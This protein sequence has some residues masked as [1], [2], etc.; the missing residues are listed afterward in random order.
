MSKLT[1]HTALYPKDGGFVSAFYVVLDK[2]KDEDGH[3][4]TVVEWHF[5]EGTRR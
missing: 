5:D 1:R 3:N 4:Y 2:K